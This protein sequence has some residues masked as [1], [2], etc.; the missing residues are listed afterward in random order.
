MTE[1][2][3]IWETLASRGEVV[4]P[5]T[6]ISELTRRIN[7]NA[8][9]TIRTLSK[10]RRLLPL[11][12]GFYYCMNP[13]EILRH[14]EV[15]ALDVFALG[16]KAKGIGSW[17]YGLHTALRLHGMSHEYRTSED[18][19]SD[20]FYRPNGVAMAGRRF[21][22]L[23]WRPGMAKFGVRK[24]NDYLVSDPEKTVLDFAYLDHY[25]MAKGRAPSGTWRE[26]VNAVDPGRL[27]NYLSHYPVN[28]RLMVEGAL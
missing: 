28:V 12:K 19:I 15:S 25:A 24:R 21:T 8:D 3:L 20:S 27:K 26:H 5:R 7:L 6:S 2:S 16:A 1:S 9:S 17:Y 22:I 14:K 23:K 11:F 18:V 4:V 10:N 13:N